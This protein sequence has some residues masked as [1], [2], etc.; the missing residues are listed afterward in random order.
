MTT[1][2][3]SSLWTP[4]EGIFAAIGIAG[5]CFFP[6]ALFNEKGSGMLISC[7][8]CGLCWPLSV[9]CLRPRKLIEKA[10]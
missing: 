7:A 1:E 4:T 2:K 3:T 6:V 5:W 8:V 10:E 9:I